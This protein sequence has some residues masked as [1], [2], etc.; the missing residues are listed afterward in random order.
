MSSREHEIA[1]AL[2]AFVEAAKLHALGIN[3]DDRKMQSK[4]CKGIGD[5]RTVIE[6]NTGSY[7]LLLPLLEHENE[8]VRFNAALTLIDDYYERVLP[9][10]HALDETS[11]TSMGTSGAMVLQMYGEPNTGSGPDTVNTAPERPRPRSRP[12]SGN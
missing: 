5:A 3:L 2:T 4:G 12:Q 8:G 7:D 6:K 11:E 1:Y 9:V 10:L